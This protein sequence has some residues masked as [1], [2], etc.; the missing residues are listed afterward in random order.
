MDCRYARGTMP[1]C[2]EIAMAD[3]KDRIEAAGG[4]PD[5]R[6]RRQPRIIEGEAVEISGDG[7]PVAPP[8]AAASR[9][10]QV[11]RDLL[12][13]LPSPRVAAAVA[14]SIVAV[15]IAAGASWIYFATDRSVAPPKGAESVTTGPSGI[16]GRA[17]SATEVETVRIA[18]ATPDRIVDKATETELESRLATVNAALAAMNDRVAALEGSI[19]DSVAAARAAAERAD[20]AV[21]AFDEAK[22]G[23]GE[24][25]AAQQL[26]RGVLDDLAGRIKTVESQQMTMRQMQDRL[27]RLASAAGATDKA[28]RVAVAAAALRNAVERDRP[29]AEELAAARTLG[30]ND[31]VLTALEPFAATGLPRQNVLFRDLSTLLPELRRAA[32]PPG[33]DL[34]YLDRLQASA[35]R[36]LNIRPVKDEPGDDPAAILSRIEYKMV[37]EDFDAIIAELDKLPEAAKEAAR[38][39]RTRATARRNA[40]E[41]VRLMATASLMKLGEPMTSG[42]SPQ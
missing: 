28:V 16:T 8:S 19:R 4:P 11:L 29:Y 34:G 13:L 42:S 22:N 21:R 24:Q 27:D 33:Q 18:Q 7:S 1:A 9:A 39:W 12:P 10:G 38:P 40:V 35:V 30:L 17:A 36:M 5:G 14:A 20:K 15:I 31:R 32:P 6:P 25:A 3:P 26:D 41:A 37:H 23:G 2:E